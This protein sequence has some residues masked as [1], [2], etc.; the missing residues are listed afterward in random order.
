MNSLHRV[1]DTNNARKYTEELLQKVEDN[2]Y[3]A[4][5][6]LIG[7][8]AD[9]NVKDEETKSTALH[10]AAKNDWHSILALLLSKGADCNAQDRTEQSPLHLAATKGHFFSCEKLLECPNLNVN[11]CNK[12]HDTPLHHAAKE[13]RLNICIMMLNHPD[14]D[15]NAKN[16][17]GM[18]PL[19]LA[20]QENHHEVIR[21]LMVSG[22]D[23]KLQDKNFHLPLHYAAQKGLPE[24]CEVLMS[25]C[26]DADREKQLKIALKDGK[27]P[28]ML[29]AKGGHHYC[30]EKLTNTNI[31]AKDKMGNTALH[32]A[33]IGG[34]EHTVSELLHMGA[35]PNTQNKVGNAPILEVSGKKRVGC[36]RILVERGADLN[37]LDKQSK[38]VLHYAA[39]KNADEC[40][41]YLLSVPTIRALMYKKDENDCTPLHTA[42]KR[43]AVECAHILLENDASPVDPCIGGMTPLHLAAAKGYTSICEILLAKNEVQ[44]S[45]ENETK[46][47]PLHLAALHGST[48]VCQM[49]L[50]KGARLTAVDKQG[51]TAL[52][53]AST[54]GY[55]GVVKF[56][57]K[58]GVPQRAKDD[59]GSTALHHA[60]YAGSLECCRALVGSA[61]AACCEVD[62][63]GKLP[64]DR[65]FENKHD[66]VFKYLLVHL[67][68][69]ENQED[70]M[71]CL[72]R[73]MH[74]ALHENRV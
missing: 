42:I 63:N 37:V 61:K 74:T 71:L 28:L 6:T 18:S 62:Q 69:K 36:L 19:H 41:T 57:S 24:S 64:L 10:I 55:D 46:A 25:N 51:R 73:Y 52:H 29:A 68:Y 39:E 5:Q 11:I 48:D 8:N 40:L 1:G 15:V 27:T 33:A 47:T 54:K 30:C 4:C 67:P 72:H 12:T 53:I 26:S 34:F 65:A 58:K 44:V 3:D 35:Q 13:G 7:K 32:Y 31:N 14:I 23:W 22:A 56:L 70:R 50:R 17:R 45:L 59:T 21:Q 43:E 66:K 38:T 9:V 2:D 49:L 16:K 20:A 60:A